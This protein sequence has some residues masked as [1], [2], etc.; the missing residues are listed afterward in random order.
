MTPPEIIRTTEG[1]DP[2]KGLAAAKQNPAYWA[3]DLLLVAAERLRDAMDQEGVTRSELARRLDVSPAYI[4]KVLRGHANMSLETLARLAFF[5][6]KRWDPVVL[7]LDERVG[8]YCAVS[9]Q[10]GHTIRTTETATCPN[11]A[12]K[13]ENPADYVPQRQSTHATQWPQR[14]AS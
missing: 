9:R 6:G 2:T 11:P 5:L 8:A 12:L 1:Y 7:D 4:T 14:M 10:G 3:E 13:P